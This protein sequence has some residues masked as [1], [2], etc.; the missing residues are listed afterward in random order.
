[1]LGVRIGVERACLAA[2]GLSLVIAGC[3]GGGHTSS[4]E[5]ST[6]ASTARAAST[7]ASTARAT[8]TPASTARATSTTPSTAHATSTS[9]ASAAASAFASGPPALVTMREYSPESLL[10][11]LVSVK[12]NGAAMLTTLI[13]EISGARRTWFRLPAGQTA[14]LRRL[15][16][17]ARSVPP[18]RPGIAPRAELY[19]LH[20]ADSRSENIQG[21]MRRQLASLVSYLSGL[22]L[23][24]CC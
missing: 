17:G 4:R 24:Y 15:V 19:T 7:A 22:M 14:R 12:P 21:P 20:I 11:Q 6:P 10:W 3:G 2:V 18:P 9:T 8:S 13:G 23:T 16:A 1:M 5:T